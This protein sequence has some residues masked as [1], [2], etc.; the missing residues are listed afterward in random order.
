MS[1]APSNLAK[2]T[3]PRLHKSVLRERLFQVEVDSSDLRL[4][5]EEASQIARH[6][7]TTDSATV[8]RLY[9]ASAGWTAGLVLLL[10]RKGDHVAESGV[11]RESKEALFNY[12]AEEVYR[13]MDARTQSILIRTALLPQISVAMAAELCADP[14]AASVLEEL[15]RKQYFVDRT[16]G[17]EITYQYHDLFRAFLDARSQI[18]LASAELRQARLCAARTL[19]AAGQVNDAV[20]L[21]QRAENWGGVARMIRAHAAELMDKGRWQTLN[22]WLLDLPEQAISSDPWLLCWQGVA[23]MSKSGLVGLPRSRH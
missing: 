10:A 7:G 16:T 2:L 12:L 19:E 18:D 20:A 4:N 21:H 6:A 15:Y 5:E 13:Q 23:Q 8:S 22:Q 9:R 3:R 11:K 17:A 1:V 14:D